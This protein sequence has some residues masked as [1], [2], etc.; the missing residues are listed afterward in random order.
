MSAIQVEILGQESM[1][2][3]AKLLAGISN[4]VDRAVKG[5]MPR[6]VSHLRSNSSK[7][8]RERYAISAKNIRTDEN[9]TVTYSYQ[10]GVQAFVRFAGSKI[11]LFR[12]DGASPKRPAVDKERLLAAKI[13]GHWAMAHPGIAASGHQLIGT[14]PTRFQNAFVAQMDSG[15][16]GIFERTGG[17]SASGGDAI[18]ELMGSSVPQMLGSREVEERLSKETADK[19]QE[20]IEHEIS[21]LLNGWGN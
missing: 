11:P 4:G 1:E 2:R 18:R 12:Y 19:F 14:S 21:R 9:V 13:A 3:A 17:E 15:H 16:I 7:A 20:R 5:A 6:A 8:V 10:N